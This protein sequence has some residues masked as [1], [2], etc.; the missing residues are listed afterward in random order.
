MQA[1]GNAESV[2]VARHIVTDER[3]VAHL[4]R[5]REAL[6]AQSPTPPV[7]GALAVRTKADATYPHLYALNKAAA[8]T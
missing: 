8:V 1:G 7:R 3:G 2:L 4:A 5:E 6:Q